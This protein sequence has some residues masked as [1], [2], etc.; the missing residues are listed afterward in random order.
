MRSLKWAALAAIVASLVVTLY[1]QEPQIFNR[2]ITITQGVLT[3]N[4][5]IVGARRPVTASGGATRTLTAANSG[6]V[7]L[8]DAATG[9]VYTLPA[10][11]VVGLTYD[12]VTTAAQSSGSNSITA[13]AGVFL[14]G[15][16]S[17]FSGEGVTP[18]STL[19]PFMF[20]G[21][22]TTHIR[23]VMNA[24]TTGGGIGTTLR[25]TCIDAT[26]WM[27]Y[28]WVNSPSGSLATPFST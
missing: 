14:Y 22:G 19:G 26:H 20:A 23:I 17:A 5:R 18:S 8:F 21:N 3:L 13:G 6:S 15:A 11:P 12:F 24:T 28:G 27:V 1:A 9:I 4:N 2:G 25:F 10:P 7:N 16:V